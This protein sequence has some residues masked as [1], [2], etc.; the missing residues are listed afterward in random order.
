MVLAH[1]LV[2]LKWDLHFYF[3]QLFDILLPAAAAF[4]LFWN[5]RRG[6]IW[7][8]LLGAGMAMLTVAGMQIVMALVAGT[9]LIPST[10]V[11]WEEA[12]EFLASIQL[13]TIA[14]NM[15]G[16]AA[17]SSKLH[18]VARDRTAG[19]GARSQLE[20]THVCIATAGLGETRKACG[21]PYSMS[22]YSRCSHSVTSP[23][24]AFA[25]SS[26]RWRVSSPSL[27]CR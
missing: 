22:K 8:T 20:S 10:M 6:W 15:V 27:R 1:Y 17:S 13:A 23:G 19:V 9:T 5:E 14:G 2:V 3:L 16:R 21:A 12:V 4:L 26:L 11:D 25:V 18:T 24:S 7:A